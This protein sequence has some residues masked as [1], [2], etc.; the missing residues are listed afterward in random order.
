[1][2]LRKSAASV[3]MVR[4]SQVN[5]LCRS[6]PWAVNELF[7]LLL[8]IQIVV[9]ETFDSLDNTL[10]SFKQMVVVQSASAVAEIIC[11]SS[12]KYG[13]KISVTYSIVFKYAAI[14]P[15]T[16]QPDYSAAWAEYYRQQGMHQHAAAIMQAAQQTQT[17]HPAQ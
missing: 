4:S 2:K 10:P 15:Q 6:S 7:C 16:G 14:N 11:K 3:V 12:C 8:A 1:M 13:L 9:S 17:G 5:L